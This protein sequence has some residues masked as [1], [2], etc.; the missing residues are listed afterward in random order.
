MYRKAKRSR[1][2]GLI[3]GQRIQEV[4]TAGGF[5]MPGSEHHRHGGL[6]FHER[7][8][9]GKC[10]ARHGAETSAL[11][12]G[13]EIDLWRIVVPVGA[14]WRAGPAFPSVELM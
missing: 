4:E 6:V 12:Q 2:Q 13:Q 5:T 10:H 1:R 7:P 9:A 3:A 11:H 8:S 14:I